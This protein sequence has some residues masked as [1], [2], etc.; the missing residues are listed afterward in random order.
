MK[1]VKQINIERLTKADR[2]ALVV[3]LRTCEAQLAVLRDVA[4]KYEGK[5]ATEL[6][7]TELQLNDACESLRSFL[8]QPDDLDPLSKTANLN[9]IVKLSV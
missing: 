9:P 3:A 8:R 2:T 6:D 5:I 7:W 1:T 4:M